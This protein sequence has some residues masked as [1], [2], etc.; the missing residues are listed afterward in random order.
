M[1]V[2]PKKNKNLDIDKIRKDFPILK[3]K[4]NNVREARRFID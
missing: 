4:S 1:L 2:T 3:I